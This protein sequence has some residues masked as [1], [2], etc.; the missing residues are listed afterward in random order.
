M[1]EYRRV[2]RHHCTESVDCEDR[3]RVFFATLQD[4]SLLGARLRGQNLPEPGSV[5]RL[6][7]STP[8]FGRTWVY[9]QICWVARGGIE[10]AGIRF[11]EP[12]F[13]LQRTWVALFI[14]E[15]VTLERRQAIRVPTELHVEVKLDGL[16]RPIEAR[17]VDLS[18]GGAQIHLPRTMRR[19]ARAD[20]YVCLPWC[21]LE[22]PAQITRRDHSDR[23]LHSVQFL[24]TSPFEQ[25]ALTTFVREELPPGL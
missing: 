24:K 10:E 15:D 21:L 1:L 4:I 2:R 19:G 5:L 25:D 12:A 9:C 16:S 13:R 11:L 17:G 20:L 7:P 8:G 23:L 14:P 6:I 18:R 3:G 22:L